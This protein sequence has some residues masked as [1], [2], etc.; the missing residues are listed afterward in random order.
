MNLAQHYNDLTEINGL[1]YA[2]QGKYGYDKPVLSLEES[3][4]ET[5]KLIKTRIAFT[6]VK[7]SYPDT[8]KMMDKAGWKIARKTLDWH[9]SHGGDSELRLYYKLFPDNKSDVDDKRTRMGS[10]YSCHHS[11]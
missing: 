1:R 10:T 8:I 2:G 3:L 4:K 9:D 7:T 6:D 11:L 5:E